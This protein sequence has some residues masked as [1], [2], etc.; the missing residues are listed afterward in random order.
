MLTQAP[1]QQ[2]KPASQLGGQATPPVEELD[3]D[4]VDD[5][6]VEEPVVLVLTLALVPP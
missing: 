6:V 4:D 1:P 2:V 5:A 3:V